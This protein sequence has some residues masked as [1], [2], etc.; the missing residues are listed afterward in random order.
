MAE[1]SQTVSR[2]LH[3]PALREEVADR[4]K[5]QWP[6]TQ[7][8]WQLLQENLAKRLGPVSLSRKMRFE[9]EARRAP[10]GAFRFESLNTANLVLEAVVRREA[11]PA[12][13]VQDNK[14][15]AATTDYWRTRLE[16]AAAIAYLPSVGRIE[17]KNHETRAWSGTGWLV[18]PDVIITNAHVARD[19]A[20]RGN[21]SWTARI[22]AL[23]R[24]VRS[25][26]DFREE[27]ERDLEEEIGVSEI[28]FVEEGNGP[29][30]ALLK[31]D[32]SASP[33]AVI[34]LAVD[35]EIQPNVEVVTVGYP[36]NDSSV[37]DPGLLRSIFNNIFDVK[38]ISP[39]IVTGQGSDYFTHDCSTLGGN[40][41]S[42]VMNLETGRALGLHYGGSYLVD[43]YAV[44]A[45]LIGKLLANLS[46]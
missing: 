3:N 2:F 16:G 33:R 29:D 15:Q 11:R 31:L 7:E 17:L 28:L 13:F 42:V 40:S 10:V 43:N 35:A 1:S 26:I 38:R 18:R 12:L 8:G 21:G 34:P 5:R 37:D 41:G 22:N 19:F 45:P 20:V 6:G 14:P 25:R 39:G 30:I 46:L 23:S 27:H 44:S 32:S 24:A 9:E 36:K 4:L